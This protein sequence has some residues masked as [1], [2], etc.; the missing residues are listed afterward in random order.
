MDEYRK[1]E[2]KRDETA[3]EIVS[4]TLDYIKGITKS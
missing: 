4:Y 2:E 3:Q 1:H